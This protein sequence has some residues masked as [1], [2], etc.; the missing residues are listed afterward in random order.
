MSRL[1]VNIFHLYPDMLNLYGDKGNIEALKRR[2]MW[3]NIDVNVISLMVGE[4]KID[5]ENADI[6]YLGG[7][8]DREQEVVLKKLLNY[9]KELKDFVEDGKTFIATCG[10]FEMIGKSFYLEGKK[11]EG[12]GLVD[13]TTSI[14]DE[15]SRLIGNVILEIDFLNSVVVGFEN[16]SGRTD[17]C[18]YKPLGKVLT[19]YG[20]NEKGEYEGLIYKNLIG[21]NLHGPLFPKN[22][23]LCDYILEST[24]K[25]K[26]N[27][28]DFLSVL[29]DELENLANNHIV[30]TYSH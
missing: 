23:K 15:K 9:K 7:G 3:R 5:F 6:I 21:T 12:L 30:S 14:S 26:Y 18:D 13:I 1:T 17:I 27:D 22:P 19:G 28:F 4:E 24:L 25:H 11:S 10:G 29:D 20:N 8:G 2:L 16:H